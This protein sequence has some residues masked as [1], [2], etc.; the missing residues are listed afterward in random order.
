MKKS[1]I[2]FSVVILLISLSFVSAGFF[3]WLT[4]DVQRSVGS[5]DSG[6][7]VTSVGGGGGSGGGCTS[8]E[9]C[10]PHYTCVTN[11]NTGKKECKYTP[12]TSIGTSGTSGTRTSLA[13][14]PRYAGWTA[15]KRAD[16]KGVCY[17]QNQRSNSLFNKRG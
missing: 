3:D 6:V 15:V 10:A 17:I 4:G 13:S 14:Q 7:R 11:P 5:T 9:D 1:L 16:E 12:G 2:V 8:N